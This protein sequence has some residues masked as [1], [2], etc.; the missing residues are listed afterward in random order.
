MGGE[1]DDR[2]WDHWM[3]SLTQ[4]TWVWVNSRS[5]WWTGR[6][7]V[8]WFM[9]W[10]RVGH[11]WTTELNWSELIHSLELCSWTQLSWLETIWCVMDSIFRSLKFINRNSTP[12]SD[13]IRRQPLGGAQVMRSELH[14]WDYCQWNYKRPQRALL[15]C[16]MKRQWEDSHLWTRKI[17]LTRGQ[18][19][20]HV[21]LELPSLQNSDK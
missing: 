9:G 14:E 7:G 18:I 13:G 6:P 1:R 12:E 8:L 11:D 5:W 21:D 16:H 19:W 2:G 15:L 3:T 20:S 4:W 10:Q 17:V